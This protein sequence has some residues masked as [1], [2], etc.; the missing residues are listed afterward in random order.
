M[1]EPQTER[2]PTDVAEQR[3]HSSKDLVSGAVLGLIATYT[4]V[5]SIRMPYYEKGIRGILS[6]PG[7]TPGLL[8]I[9][10][11]IMSIMLMVRARGARP[12]FHI[13]RPDGEA[14]RVI[15]VVAVLCLYVA[16]IKPLGYVTATF[17]MLAVF[18]I[19]F[20][21]RERTVGRVLGYGIVLSALT[22]ALLWYVF[23]QIFLIP[24]P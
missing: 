7:L 2:R 5:E 21:G 23:G 14:W 4:L 10:L 12:R 15:G 9:G 1:S 8:S 19:G 11:I 3:R 17:I 18:Q 24:L 13:P 22:T 16:A 6:S 20:M